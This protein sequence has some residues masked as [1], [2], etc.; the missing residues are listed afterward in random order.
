MD[1]LYTA[2]VSEVDHEPFTTFDVDYAFTHSAR[3]SKLCLFY[4]HL[5]AKYISIPDRAKGS[6]ED[7][8]GVLQKHAGLGVF[9][10]E[11]MRIGP[12]KESVVKPW[13]DYRD[14]EGD[15]T[16]E[17]G[18]EVAI[19]VSSARQDGEMAGVKKEPVQT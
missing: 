13:K 3:E 10:M 11:A 1:R 17:V 7:W 18:R 15:G 9:V 14:V 2:H 5:L 8:Y 16:E 6:P 19:T 12:E 4:K